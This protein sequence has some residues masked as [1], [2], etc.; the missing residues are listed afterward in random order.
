SR[1]F[2]HTL[3]PS[4]RR[5][6]AGI[7]P[8][9]RN[10]KPRRYDG[11]ISRRSLRVK[12]ERVPVENKQ[13]RC[14]S[15]E[16]GAVGGRDNIHRDI[17]DIDVVWNYDMKGKLV[18]Q[19]AFPLNRLTVAAHLEANDIVEQRGREFVRWNSPPWIY[20]RERTGTDWDRKFGMEELARA[21]AG[22]HIKRNRGLVRGKQYCRRNQSN[23]DQ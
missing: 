13:L 15:I 19:V 16:V 20:Q 10:L 3:H 8:P 9:G 4:D 11:L 1:E 7:L 21:V 12:N 5:D 14:R 17:Q 2:N 6:Y 18:Y 23:Y 22:I